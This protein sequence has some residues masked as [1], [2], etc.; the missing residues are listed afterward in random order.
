MTSASRPRQTT[1]PDNIKSWPLG[2]VPW[3]AS[4]EGLYPDGGQLAPVRRRFLSAPRPTAAAIGSP[5]RAAPRGRGRAGDG[6]GVRGRRGKPSG[7]CCGSCRQPLDLTRYTNDVGGQ[8]PDHGRL[9]VPDAAG[10]ALPWQGGRERRRLPAPGDLWSVG[11]NRRAH[12]APAAP[13]RK[14]NGKEEEIY[15]HSHDP[16]GGGPR[17][18]AWGGGPMRREGKR[19]RASDVPTTQHENRM[20]YRQGS[21]GVEI[22][23]A[24][25]LPSG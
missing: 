1:S 7:G 17:Q 9:L 3:S 10:G 15:P 25:V 16:R 11:P 4:F 22:L 24:F 2:V 21:R 8:R 23:A 5:S 20:K 14:P 6:V 19:K 18:A 13:T 12:H